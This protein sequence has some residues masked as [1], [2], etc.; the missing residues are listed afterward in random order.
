MSIFRV[1]MQ[2]PMDG[3]L[4]RDVVTI[5]PHFF[6]DNPSALLNALHANLLAWSGTAPASWTLKAYDAEHPKPN[7]P[8]AVKE[9]IGT[10]PG[11]DRPREIALC[12]SY[13]TGFNRPSFRGRLYLPTRWLS[14]SCAQ[15]PSATQKTEVLDFGKSVLSK[16]LPASHNW[17]VWS[18]KYKKSQGGVSNIW[19]DDEWD[20]VRSRGLRAT[21]RITATIP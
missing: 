18:T 3:T 6:G 5:N 2:F 16:N 14:G 7:Y 8:V 15:R 10:T 12:L 13:Y 1:T 4:A 9:Q 11:N 20:T 19:V 21:S 17:V